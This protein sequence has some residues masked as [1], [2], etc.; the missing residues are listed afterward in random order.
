[1]TEVK[2]LGISKTMFIVGLII[3][4]LASSLISDLAAKQL[5]VGSKGDKGDKGD[6]GSQ[7]VFAQWS[8]TWKTITWECQWFGVLGGEILFSHTQK[9]IT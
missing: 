8:V 3:A 4:I 6:P 1:M 7:L 2:S 5:A 9:T